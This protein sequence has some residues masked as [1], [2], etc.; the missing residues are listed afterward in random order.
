[1][2]AVV[3]VARRNLLAD[4]ARLLMSIAGVAFA[5]LL[6]LLVTSLYR[7]WSSF[8]SVFVSLPGDV[9]V[10]E[11]GTNDPLN[12]TSV[13]PVRGGEALAADPGV[14]AVIPVRVR[15]TVVD[16]EGER[17]RVYLMSLDVPGDLPVA[18]ETRRRFLPEP[19]RINIDRVLAAAAGVRVGDRIAVLD[20]TLEVGDVHT[21]G[22]RLIQLAYLH[23]ADAGPLYGIEG[24]VNFFLLSVRPGAN[25]AGV[26][27]RAA[28]AVAQS[29]S[30][31]SADFADAFGDLVNQ[32]FLPVVGALVGIG[33]LV[34]G[35]LIALT[36]Y[37]ATAERARDFGV[38]KALGASSRFLYRI[39]VAQS[40][41]VGSVGASVGVL[42]AAGAA[43]LIR[44]SVPEFVTDLRVLDVAGVLAIAIAV[45]VLAAY[46]P[47]RRIARID[48]GMVFRV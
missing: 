28:A 8:G 44:R 40:L 41:I 37:T 45:S 6:I 15:E 47:V 17:V 2:S 9:W 31:S 27:R 36:I 35:A 46:V 29:E 33:F 3:P 5:V 26:Q 12:S 23:P 38:L 32:G 10:A 13:L 21:G 1:M 42:G 48:P 18:P 20:R 22:N 14:A 25:V 4:R 30:H 19:G 39:V 7:G 43:T 34:G 24:Y 16:A 11:R